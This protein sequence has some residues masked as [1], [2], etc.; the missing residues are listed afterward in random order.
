MKILIRL[1]IL[2]AQSQLFHFTAAQILELLI[3]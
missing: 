3:T 2:T 1:R